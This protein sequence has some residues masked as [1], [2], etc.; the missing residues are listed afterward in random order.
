MPCFQSHLV[1]FRAPVAHA[2]L[3]GGCLEMV[4][5]WRCKHAGPPVVSDPVGTHARTHTSRGGWVAPHPRGVVS[6][7][8]GRQVRCSPA[9]PSPVCRYH[10]AAR[11][12]H[13]PH[14]PITG[15]AQG[16]LKSE[17]AHPTCPH[18]SH[19]ALIQS[20]YWVRPLLK[21]VPDSPRVFNEQTASTIHCDF[22]IYPNL[23]YTIL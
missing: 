11:Q 17:K 6:P 12:A 20:R 5:W 18:P 1:F 9:L 7:P 14:R 19:P 21:T 23:Y 3:V 13:Y 8:A 15:G 10:S 2:P 16:T 22:S 4:G